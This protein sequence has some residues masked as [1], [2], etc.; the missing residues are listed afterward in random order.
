MIKTYR[1]NPENL[2]GFSITKGQGKN[3][4]SGNDKGFG[5]VTMGTDGTLELGQ[6]SELGLVTAEIWGTY[7][8][9]I[10]GF[11][12][13]LKNTVSF[14]FLISHQSQK[15]FSCLLSW[16]SFPGVAYCGPV[17]LCRVRGSVYL[18]LGLVPGC[19]SRC[20]LC[21]KLL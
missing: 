18:D 14:G 2:N 9:Q 7:S 21:R 10:S 11:S 12:L 6:G 15:T 20:S 13:P 4:T 1:A 19:E 3:W 16:T 17:N 5:E 8:P